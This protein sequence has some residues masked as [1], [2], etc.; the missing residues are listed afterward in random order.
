MDRERCQKCVVFFVL[1]WFGFFFT[2]NGCPV[3]SYLGIT[4]VI[5]CVW[6]SPVRKKTGSDDHFLSIR[7][8]GVYTGLVWVTPKSWRVLKEREKHLGQSEPKCPQL[9]YCYWATFSFDHSVTHPVVDYFPTNPFLS[10]FPLFVINKPLFYVMCTLIYQNFWWCFHSHTR[11]YAVCSYKHRRD[12]Y[13]YIHTYIEI[14][15]QHHV[16]VC[17][18]GV[19]DHVT[20][21]YDVMLFCERRPTLDIKSLHYKLKL[22]V[23]GTLNPTQGK[24]FG[25]VVSPVFCGPAGVPVGTELIL[26]L[27][28]ILVLF[29]CPS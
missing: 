9:A 20:R 17:V 15:Q 13:K 25:S 28:W 11:H 16:W 23:F 14:V 24:S 8:P 1:F 3:F 29:V 19:T 26:D 6:E 4:Q 7:S 5:V 10:V 2:M 22:Q 18:S 12:S 27:A 21:W